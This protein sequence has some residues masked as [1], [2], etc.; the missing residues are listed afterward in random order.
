MEF[1]E[2]TTE[3]LRSH[4]HYTYIINKLVDELKELKDRP[5]EMKWM[6][7]SNLKMFGSMFKD[8]LRGVKDE[9]RKLGIATW[10]EDK[11]DMVIV[12]VTKR[13][14]KKRYG[15]KRRVLYEDIEAL[16]DKVAHELATMPKDFP[17]YKP[18][19]ERPKWQ[20]MV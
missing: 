3:L 17:P 14:D 19:L 13:G 4:L 5:V 20:Q 10:I 15:V 6:L 16:M 8:R 2:H 9:L 18:E 11:G 7:E 12:W 1:D